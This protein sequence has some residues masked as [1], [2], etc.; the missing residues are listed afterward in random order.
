LV[1]AGSAAG[2]LNRPGSVTIK[3]KV[4]GEL[5][6]T[7]VQDHELVRRHD[8]QVRRQDRPPVH[9][10]SSSMADK[11]QVSKTQFPTS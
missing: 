11:Q 10:R 7:A 5:D 3:D 9:D 2:C 6:E 4:T 1:A 8:Q